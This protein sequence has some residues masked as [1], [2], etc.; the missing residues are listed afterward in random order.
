MADRWGCRC[1]SASPGQVLNGGPVRA[2]AEQVPDR[3]WSDSRLCLEGVHSEIADK[4]LK[5]TFPPPN[6]A[7]TP[8]TAN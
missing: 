1:I 5:P 3:V 2:V 8:Y 7:C 6:I 4:L